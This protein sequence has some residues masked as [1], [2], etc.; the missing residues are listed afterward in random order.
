MANSFIHRLCQTD[1]DRTR[2]IPTHEIVSAFNLVLHSAILT[3]AQVKNAYNLT[4]E[5]EVGFDL[6]IDEILAGTPAPTLD[7]KILRIHMVEA[8]LGIWEIGDGVGGKRTG[9]STEDEIQSKL[10][11]ISDGP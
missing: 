5:D 7:E 3:L 4:A 9:F 10:L 8:V 11:L 2:H 6:L 1:A